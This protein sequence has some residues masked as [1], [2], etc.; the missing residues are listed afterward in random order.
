MNKRFGLFLLIALMGAV[1]FSC[2]KKPQSGSSSTEETPTTDPAPTDPSP[3]VT[4]T[5]V[6]SLVSVGAGLNFNSSTGSWSEMSV[7]PIDHFPEVIYYDRTAPVSPVAGA[8]KYAR[9]SATGAWSI[10]I[11]DANSPLTANTNTCGGGATTAYC[12]GAPNVAVPT[13]SQAQIYD[14]GHFVTAGVSAPVV[15]YAYGTGGASSST[16]G[17]S[18]RFARKTASGWAV[19]TAVTGAQILAATVGTVGPQLATLAY[20]I[21]AVRM[22]V[23]DSNRVH[24]T[25]IVYAATANNSVYLYS[26]RA[27]DGT[28]TTPSVISTTTPSTLAVV[29]GAPT[30]LAGTGV[31]Q[32]GAAFCKYGSNGSSADAVGMLITTGT[33]DN[34]PSASTQGFLLRCATAN[35]DGSCATWQGL[36]FTAGCSGACVT[37]APTSTAAAAN[38]FGRSDLVVDPVSGKIVLSYFSA[39]PSLTSPATIATGILSTQSPAVCTSGLSSTA[40]SAVR[41]HPTAAQGT[42]GLRVASDGTNVYLASLTAAAGTSIILNKQT[43]ALGANWNTTPDQITV[44]ST[45]NTVGGGFSYDASTGVLWGSYGA[46]TAGAAGATGQDIKAFGAYPG[47]IS[48]TNGQ[49]NNWYVDQTNS[50]A[51]PTAVPMLDAAVAPNGNVGYTYFYQ[52]PGAAPGPNSRLYYGNRGGTAL[53]P[54]FGEKIVSNSIAGATTFLNGLHPS[55][56]F[57]SASNPVISFLDQGG[58]ANGGYLMVARSPNGGITFDLDRVDGSGVNTKNVGQY[59]STDL[60][61]ADTIGV[62]YYEFST[63]ANAQRLRFAKRQKNGAWIRYVVDGPGS[64]GA[65]CDTTASAGIGV[66]SQFK[67][68]STGRPVIVYQGIVSGTKSLKLAYATEA[69]SSATYT[70]KCMTIDTTSQ[71][72]NARG[73]GIDLFLDSLDKPYIAHYDAGI[74]ALRVVT[75]PAGSGVLTCGATGAAAFS[76][77]RLNYVIGPV[78][79][80][81]SKPGIRVDS[82]GKIWVSFHSSADMG[83]FV[84]SKAS[85]TSGGWDVAPE[86]VERTPNNVGSSATGQHGVLLLNSSKKPMMFYRGFENWIRYFSREK[87]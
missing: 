78:T 80:I 28:W 11:V 1:S 61:M 38:Q 56:A 14:I 32:A 67:W 31:Q 20:P 65:G 59:T 12:I 15:V 36:D 2:A 71:G 75:C 50:V 82:T 57:D 25:F 3:T 83:L 19:E 34:A 8:L 55:L 24:L 27:A 49:V 51:Q 52:E 72:S 7:D 37:T 5:D 41:A 84:A 17:K 23:D 18:I 58:A 42:L 66:Y 54:L 6:H 69:E 47:D 40:W 76:G 21:T 53:A 48:T 39:A 63:G 68:T 10:D 45:T 87:N 30:Y 44:D 60:S 81:A 9:M 86:V 73:E 29:S 26:M 22:L 35:V 64:T 74:G 43:A 85:G 77:E 13:A 79:S 16:S 33:L 46:L 4:Y 62:S 70:W